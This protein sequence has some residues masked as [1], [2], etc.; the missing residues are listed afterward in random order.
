MERWDRV[1]SRHWQLDCATELVSGHGTIVAEYFDVGCSR[2]R[3]WHRR[4]Q[5]AALLAALGDPLRGFDAI[6]VGEYERAFSGNQL[7]LTRFD[8]QG[9]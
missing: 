9:R 1:T 2:R 6:V 5:S 7:G 4:P 8:G 3:S